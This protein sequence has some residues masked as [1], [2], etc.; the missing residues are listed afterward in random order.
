MPRMVENMIPD[1][2]LQDLKI[3]E[4]QGREYEIVDEGNRIYIIFKNYCLPT[5]LYNKDKTDL[6]IFTTPQYPN[7][8]FDMFWV[9]E[10]ITLKSGGQPKSAEQFE[11]YLERRWRRFSYHPY[12]KKPWNP[13]EDDVIQ[14][15]LYVNQRLEKGD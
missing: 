9:D 12:N 4:E 10:T 15:M 5:G 2:L 6:M 3:F 14:F 11:T 7:A 13:S 1:E 8:G